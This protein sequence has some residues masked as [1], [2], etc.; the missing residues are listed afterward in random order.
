MALASTNPVQ[1]PPDDPLAPAALL[2][3]AW[4]LHLVRPEEAYSLADAA[5]IA[6]RVTEQPYISAWALLTK[7]LARWRWIGADARTL[8]IEF[9]EAEIAMRALNDARGLRLAELRDAAVH[10]K[11]GLWQESLVYFEALI[12]RFDVNQFDADNFYPLLGLAT[13]YVYC[14][15]LPEGLRFGYA[16]LHMSQQLNLAPQQATMALPLGVALMAV[17]D[18]DEAATIFERAELVAEQIESPMLLKAIRTNLAIAYRRL[19]RF[20]EAEERMQWVLT[21]PPGMIGG[22][23]FA[24]FTATE[25]Y[26]QQG[27]LDEA[28]SELQR[29]HQ[30]VDSHNP[31]L[32]DAAKAHYL[33]GL[34]CSR[35]ELLDEACYHLQHV[36]DLLPQVS[37]L[38]FSDR[39]QVHEEYAAVLARLGRFEEAY[40]AQLRSTQEYLSAVSVLN[41][42]RQFSMQVRHEISRVR[43]QLAEATQERRNLQTS[44]RQL[45]LAIEQTLN[46]AERFKNEANLDALTGLLNRRYLDGTLPQLL[47]MA[48]QSAT[49]VAIAII[50]LD[51]FKRVNDDYG[52]AMGDEVLRGFARMSQDLLRGSDII[53]RYGGEEFVAA[54]IGCG[55]GAAEKRLEDLQQR[56]REA[57]FRLNGHELSGITFTAGVAIYPEDGVTL[58]QLMKRAD[59]RLYRAKDA[60]RQRIVTDD[61]VKLFARPGVATGGSE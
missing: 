3:R 38:R 26:I 32:L 15:N 43:A 24:H 1:N 18:P 9:K 12:G 8:D 56:V 45:A 21:Q 46:E 23:Q 4:N 11:L 59:E 40:R 13:S 20:V 10:F 48:Q 47:T 54:I 5:Y 28:Q 49:P 60:G 19:N 2:A 17:R 29:A 61:T 55:P 39:A 36:A 57:C 42:V 34:I 44:N 6:A 14:G 53:G 30:F 7:A 52:H 16:G 31:P 41:R 22:Q 37:A 27:R 58:E 25:L 50:D 51:R 33:S 35:R